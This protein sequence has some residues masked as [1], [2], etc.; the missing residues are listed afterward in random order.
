MAILAKPKGTPLKLH[1]QNVMDEGK[2][3]LIHHPFVLKKYKEIQ[4]LI[5]QND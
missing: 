1:T 3:I 4:V 2:E 5:W